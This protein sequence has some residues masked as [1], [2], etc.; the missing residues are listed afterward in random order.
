MKVFKVNGEW[1]KAE[2]MTE[3]N[4]DV[5]IKELEK[6]YDEWIERKMKEKEMII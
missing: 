3:E 1:I 2:D 6:Y 4:W 5:Y